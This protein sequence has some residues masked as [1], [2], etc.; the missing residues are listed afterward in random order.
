MSFF[1]IALVSTSVIV[2]VF[3]AVNFLDIMIE[4][5]RDYLI[6]INYSL[7]NFPKTF[8]KLFPFIL[9]FS[10]Y[11][12]TTK[13]ELNN[14]LIILWNFGIN[15]IQLVNFIF[16]ASLIL[17]LIQLIFTSIL[18]PKT[19]E[20]ARAF[21]RTSEVNFYGNFIKTQKFND[22]IKGV[23]IY[24][25]KKDEEG[26]LYNLYLKKEI[27]QNEFKI[28]YAKKGIFK[29]INDVPILVLLDG[30]TISGSDDEITNFS[31]SKSDFSLKNIETNTTT[32]PKNQEISSLK[33]IKCI[34]N[35]K[36]LKNNTFDNE[37]KK[38]E[39]CNIQNIENLFKEFYKR[40]IIPIYI[41]LLSMI[42]FLLIITSKE[43]SNYMKYRMFTFILGL[44]III[45]SETTIRFISKEFL[46]N[47]SLLFLPI[48][49]NLILY[50]SFTKKF[51]ARR[52]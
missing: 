22:A 25:E 28:T 41:P 33:L 15:K 11:Y 7:L 26:N 48:I 4:D 32:Y 19:Q 38:I 31:F 27:N 36:N 40:F 35:I 34:K 52:I 2:W 18:V 13:I 49:F 17:L 3:Q 29:K 44:I 1:L 9:F 23:T 20:L 10:I 6:Y 45:F 39:N 24:S 12:V 8:S 51:N 50:M 46:Q 43:K 14:E 47:L 37:I 21:L 42:P 5:G 30:T 16:K